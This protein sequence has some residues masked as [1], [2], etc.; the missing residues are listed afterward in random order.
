MSE[1]AGIDFGSI[2]GVALPPGLQVLLTSLQPGQAPRHAASLPPSPFAR[3]QDR[4]AVQQRV[5]FA[6][7]GLS[8]LRE[9]GQV[10]VL[11]SLAL[12]GL[13]A[14]QELRPGSS[15][16]LV[17]LYAP[18]EVVL[19]VETAAGSAS[20]VTTMHVQYGD[21]WP[22]A[23]PATL[24][25]VSSG[26]TT[27]V[28]VHGHQVGVQHHRPGQTRLAWQQRFL[29][30]DG[31]GGGLRRRGLRGPPAGAGGADAG[32]VRCA[33]WR[34][35]TVDLGWSCLDLPALLDTV[36]HGLTTRCLRDDREVVAATA[37]LTTCAR[38]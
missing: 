14:P 28:S 8:V 11:F 22:P 33:E 3:R 38:R 35:V 26:D 6:V 25:L 29:A 21:P 34:L 19:E 31:G 10:E 1:T 37:M 23:R 36:D 2:D 4:E 32:A 17:V 30:E 18:D 13:I 27:M 12:E 15:A 9:V 20:E 5:G 16:G 7:P 24:R